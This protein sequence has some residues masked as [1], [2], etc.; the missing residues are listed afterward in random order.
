MLLGSLSKQQRK[1]ISEYTIKNGLNDKKETV[2]TY[3]SDKAIFEK[4]LNRIAFSYYNYK[5]S[6]RGII[7]YKG[8][9]NCSRKMSVSSLSNLL[10]YNPFVNP[11]NDTSKPFDSNL[12]FMTSEREI[13]RHISEKQSR[14]I[15]KNCSKLCYYTSERKFMSKK[16]G[17]YS[18]KVGFLTLT[19]PEGT[20]T[21]QFLKAFELF[22]DYLR[23]TANCVFVWKKEFGEMGNNLHVHIMVNNF[24]PYYL[25]DWKWKRLLL[26]QG[27]IWPKNEKG[28]DTKAHYRIE[29]PKNMKQT[30]HYMA[31][32]MAKVDYTPENVG[33]LWGKS[34]ILDE[35]KEIILIEESSINGE[36]FTLFS[37][38]KVIGT[39]W[40][41]MCL[42]DLLKVS[43]L[44]PEIFKVFE[45]QFY[46]FQNKITLPQRFQFV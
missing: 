12:G 8:F 3:L 14:D 24:I 39:D 32:Y 22:L 25:V 17:K 5:L 10:S 20:S 21:I 38:F 34:K 37:K 33:Y 11:E 27:V 19:S 28:E 13:K 30:G 35:C 9:E 29:L 23:R 1:K 4:D 18:F 7:S 45:K 15:K 40:V 36:L 16:S 43:D 6:H 31:K 42:V 2:N 41:K 44:C 46:E 26:S